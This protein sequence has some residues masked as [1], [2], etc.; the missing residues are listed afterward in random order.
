MIYMDNTYIYCL[1]IKEFIKIGITKD[2]K[3]RLKLISGNCPYEI[4]KVI[5]SKLKSRNEV[6][7]LE[8]KLQIE[9][10]NYHRKGEWYYDTKETQ[11]ILNHYFNDCEIFN[12]DE[13]Y[14]INN[15]SSGNKSKLSD[16]EL[17]EIYIRINNK[18]SYK[19]ISKDYNISAST[20]GQ[21]K[22]N[23]R[24]II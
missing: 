18:E 8:Y 11:E 1:F 5:Y 12:D 13:L 22:N 10:T 23:M 14:Y 17:K 15:I 2:I 24:R 9:L 7:L 19:S 6:S 3:K 21:I 16:N 20:I 4:E